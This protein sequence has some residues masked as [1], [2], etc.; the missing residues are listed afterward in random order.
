MSFS[1]GKA[2]HVFADDVF[3]QRLL[4]SIDHLSMSLFLHGVGFSEGDAPIEEQTLSR[5]FMG[6]VPVFITTKFPFGSDLSSSEVMSG[7]S[8]ICRL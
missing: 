3:F 1:H 4:I 6:C 5:V 8:I 7:R 2:G